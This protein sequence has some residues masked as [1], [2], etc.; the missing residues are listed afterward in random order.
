[1]ESY[2][3]FSSSSFP[4]PTPGFSPWK[5][6]LSS[7]HSSLLSP[8]FYTSFSPSY[9]ILFLSSSNFFLSFSPA[10]LPFFFLL[11]FSHSFSSSSFFFFLYFFL[12]FS[13]FFSFPFLLLFFSLFPLFP[14]FIL[15]FWLLPPFPLLSFSCLCCCFPSRPPIIFS[16]LFISCPCQGGCYKIK[17]MKAKG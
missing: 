3:F 6:P 15:F 16:F 8:L 13:L 2:F 17:K 1:M 5:S 12:L 14:P 4:L 9:F 11:F 10:F 7:Y